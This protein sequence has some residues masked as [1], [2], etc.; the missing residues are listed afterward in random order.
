MANSLAGP[1]RETVLTAYATS[2]HTLF[3]FV[4]AVYVV[5]TILALMLKDIEIPKRA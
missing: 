5:E 3:L 4:A 2:F 1:V